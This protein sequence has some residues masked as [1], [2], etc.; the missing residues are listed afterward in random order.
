MVI[1]TFSSIRKF[2]DYVQQMIKDG[3]LLLPF[4]WNEVLK[5]QGYYS[6]ELSPGNKVIYDWCQEKFGPD[7]YVWTGS[8]FWFETETDAIMFTLRWGRD[9]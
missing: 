7:H 6:V 2:T 8:K 4:N 3:K 5:D 9:N 1:N